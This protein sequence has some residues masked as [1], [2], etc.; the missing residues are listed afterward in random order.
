MGIGRF[1][2]EK[3]LSIVCFVTIFVVVNLYLFC[4][5]SFK[6]N[7]VDL[8]YIDFIITAIYL[9]FLFMKYSKWK[10]VYGG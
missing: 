10:K 2:K 6:D 9:V 1:I 5:T 7:L 8:I 3:S 4:L